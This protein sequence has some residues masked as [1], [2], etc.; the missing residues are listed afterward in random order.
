MCEDKK[1]TLY[2]FFLNLSMPRCIILHYNLLCVFEGKEYHVLNMIITVHIYL[3]AAWDM[4]R[5]GKSLI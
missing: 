3:H 4:P 5:G 2:Q 1:F